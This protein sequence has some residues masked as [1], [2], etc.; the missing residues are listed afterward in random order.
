MVASAHPF[1]FWYETILGGSIFSLAISF[2]IACCASPFRNT[3]SSCPI[4]RG[5]T[6][7]Q[8]LP[9]HI[10]NEHPGHYLL[11]GM[12]ELELL[13]FIHEGMFAIA[14]VVLFLVMCGC[15]SVVSV[16]TTSCYV[17]FLGTWWFI[18]LWC[19]WC[20]CCSALN[21]WCL[22]SLAVSDGSLYEQVVLGWN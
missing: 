1:P 19:G 10:R 7:P 15:W 12:V 13:L 16:M 17:T 6:P 11:W 18:M 9:I 22:K 5:L 2:W 21:I 4:V 14:N 3:L 20:G 8:G